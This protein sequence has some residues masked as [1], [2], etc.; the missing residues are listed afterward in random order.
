M[1]FWGWGCYLISLTLKKCSFIT[2][3][4]WNCKHWPTSNAPKISVSCIGWPPKMRLKLQPQKF[5]W[6]I[7][8]YC[9]LLVC[10]EIFSASAFTMHNPNLY[11]PQWTTAAIKNSTSFYIFWVDHNLRKPRSQFCCTYTQPFLG[12]V[13]CCVS[14][15]P[16]AL[17]S[18]KTQATLRVLLLL[19]KSSSHLSCSW[20]SHSSLISGSH[21]G[22]CGACPFF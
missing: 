5:A 20:P 17:Q 7:S 19:W 1:F 18:W 15:L 8:I 9:V 22:Q 11:T 16:P 14:R 21:I 3:A 13:P 10:I 4:T 12:P 6:Y 2:F